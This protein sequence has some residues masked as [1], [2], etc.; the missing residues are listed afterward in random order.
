MN[1]FDLLELEV[2]SWTGH[3]RRR[4]ASDGRGRD[5]AAARSVPPNVPEL[6]RTRRPSALSTS[7]WTREAPTAASRWPSTF[8][9]ARA[10][11]R[12][13]PAPASIQNCRYQSNE[14]STDNLFRI[15]ARKES[16]QGKNMSLQT[17]AATANNHPPASAV[18][19]GWL[20]CSDAGRARAIRSVA[21]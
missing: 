11:P 16:S 17:A 14:Q 3:R 21:Q 12:R 7:S 19:G 5:R 6:R 2:W 20:P 15:Y 18:A 10:S 8:R 1:P 13:Q 9:D 4:C